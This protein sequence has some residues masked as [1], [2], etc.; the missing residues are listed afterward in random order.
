MRLE[1]DS[2]D[3]HYV[4]PATVMGILT[5]AADCGS[6]V[7]CGAQGILHVKGTPV[8]VA[9]RLGLEIAK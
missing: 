8:N 7:W 2:G 9:E 5:R 4:N 1:G 6:E 3:P